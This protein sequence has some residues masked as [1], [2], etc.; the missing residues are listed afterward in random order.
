MDTRK[1]VAVEFVSHRYRT[2]VMV[3]VEGGDI[4]DIAEYYDDEMSYRP[5]AFLWLS[6]EAARE[7]HRNRCR[8]LIQR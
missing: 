2:V 6:V 8:Q 5:A 3:E 4:L 7:M 1:I